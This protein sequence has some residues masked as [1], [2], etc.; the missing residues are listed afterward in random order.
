MISS[1]LNQKVVADVILAVITNIF[2]GTM[3]PKSLFGPRPTGQSSMLI[4]LHYLER[5]KRVSFFLAAG[6]CVKTGKSCLKGILLLA[7]FGV[8]SKS[9]GRR[10]VSK[11]GMYTVQACVKM[12]F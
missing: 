5:I 12:S 2:F 3:R 7:F 10:R 8:L 11:K 4:R 9:Y 1:A 6:F